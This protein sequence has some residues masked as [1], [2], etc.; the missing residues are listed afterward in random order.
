MFELVCVRT[1]EVVATAASYSE[2]AEIQFAYKEVDNVGL[3]IIRL[4]PRE[5]T[6]AEVETIILD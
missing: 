1:G 6:E 5:L 4:D 2:A 3:D